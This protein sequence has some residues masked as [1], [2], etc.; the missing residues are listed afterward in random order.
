MNHI[1]G[2]IG[3]GG[4]GGMEGRRLEG[5]GRGEW[6]CGGRVERGGG[7]RVLR[8]TCPLERHPKATLPC[9]CILH[10]TGVINHTLAQCSQA[11]IAATL[12][13]ETRAEARRRKGRF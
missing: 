11:D 4:V 5:K 13:N 2:E 12:R 8:K 6:S 1:V 9:L 7:E 3:R 10:Y